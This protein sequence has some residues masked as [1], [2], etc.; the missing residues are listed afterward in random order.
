MKKVLI[1][2]TG[3]SCRSS[4]AEALINHY[5]KDTWQAYS[6]G[7]NPSSVNPRAIQAL[8]ELDI[9]TSYLKSKGITEF[10]YMD[11][12]DLV[13]TVCDHAKQTC[14]LFPKAV[15]QIHIS[16]EDPV[17]YT[18]APDEEAKSSFRACRDDIK[19]RIVDQLDNLSSN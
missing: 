17:I 7:T 15:K 10:L 4:M 19:A 2:C 13:I 5:L 14:P 6:A 12:L 11:D 1:L 8:Q 3:N 9:D 18:N 16:V